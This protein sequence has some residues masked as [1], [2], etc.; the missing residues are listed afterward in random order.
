MQAS[1]INIEACMSTFDPSGQRGRASH[2]TGVPTAPAPGRMLC[3][4][5][6][7]V[8][9]PPSRAFNPGEGVGGGRTS[10][11]PRWELVIER[12]QEQN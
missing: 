6:Q 7:Y 2:G 10:G 3:H 9:R 8:T 4:R 11:V 12:G 1:I 5:W